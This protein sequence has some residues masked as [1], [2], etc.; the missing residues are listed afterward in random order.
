MYLNK[1]F[2]LGNLTNDPDLRQ[3]P[4]GQSVC[5][6]SVATNSFFVDREG[7][8]QKRTEFHNVVVWGK[9]AEIAAQFLKKGSSVLIEGRIQT[10]TWQDRQG[11]QRKTTEIVAER[12]QL[13]PRK[14]VGESILEEDKNEPSEVMEITS[15]IKDELPEINLEESEINL[16]D[17][18]F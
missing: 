15:E 4:Q 9:Q 7:N 12:M 8:K 17:I 18:P 2:I 14:A 3:T 1:A 16:D 13:G 11:M 10:R 5:S 6:F